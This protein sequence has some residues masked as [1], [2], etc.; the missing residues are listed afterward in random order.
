[1]RTVLA[2]LLGHYA[3]GLAHLGRFRRQCSGAV[4]E[5]ARVEQLGVEQFQAAGFIALAVALL[6]FDIGGFEQLAECLFVVGAVLADIDTGE[7]QPDAVDQAD[8]R[9]TEP[10]TR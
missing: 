4:G 5:W 8:E 6:G 3:E 2:D 1:M 9:V 10:T 7:V